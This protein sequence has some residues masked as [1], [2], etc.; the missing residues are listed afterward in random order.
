MTKNHTSSVSIEEA[1]AALRTMVDSEVV[2]G[3]CG[4]GWGHELT[5]VVKYCGVSNEGR[6]PVLL[7]NPTW[8]R[9]LVATDDLSVLAEEM[10]TWFAIQSEVFDSA[11][12]SP[13]G[14]TLCSA[15]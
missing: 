14:R 7:V 11:K 4:K 6:R 2:A 15:A 9:E 13:T 8:L 10:H 12:S 3:S 5:Q 1:E